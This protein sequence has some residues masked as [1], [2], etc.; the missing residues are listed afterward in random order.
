MLLRMQRLIG[1]RDDGDHGGMTNS[2]LRTF[3]TQVALPSSRTCAVLRA[4][5]AHAFPAQFPC[6]SAPA[7]LQPTCQQQPSSHPSASSSPPTRACARLTTP[8]PLPCRRRLSSPARWCKVLQPKNTFTTPSLLRTHQRALCTSLSLVV[9]RRNCWDAGGVVE[10]ILVAGGAED[11]K[12]CA[13]VCAT[14]VALQ[15]SC[16]WRAKALH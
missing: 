3:L 6:S 10:R 16:N 2:N 13:G 14:T 5:L 15:V 11:V 4:H 9:T 12:S 7:R 8:L 1:T